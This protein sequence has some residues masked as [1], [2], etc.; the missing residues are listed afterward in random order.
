MTDQ[1]HQATPEADDNSPAKSKVWFYVIAAVLV[2][3]IA[4]F[5]GGWNFLKQKWDDAHCTGFC[6][7]SDV[8]KSLKAQYRSSGEFTHVWDVKCV[9][10]SDNRHYVCHVSVDATSASVRVTVSPDH[11]TWLVSGTQ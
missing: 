3:A 7:A 8:Q 6:T 9:Q 1:I 4:L 10:D 11:K 5:A 2:V